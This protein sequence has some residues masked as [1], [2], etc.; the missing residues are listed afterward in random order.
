[1]HYTGNFRRKHTAK[2]RY[3]VANRTPDKKNQ[4]ANARDT[5]SGRPKSGVFRYNGSHFKNIEKIHTGE[6]FLPSTEHFKP[7][8]FEIYSLFF[9]TFFLNNF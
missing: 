3:T 8:N 5:K 9:D 7:R 4:A 6:R 1:M 2:I